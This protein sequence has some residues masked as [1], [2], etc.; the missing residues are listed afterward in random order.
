MRLAVICCLALL[1]IVG[2]AAPITT[3]AELRHWCKEKSQSYFRKKNIT[4]YNGRANGWQQENTL[5]VTGEWR[6]NSK[7]VT[8]DCQL[9]KGS[10]GKRATFKVS[11]Q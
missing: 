11:E 9:N 3:S 5:Y 1:P 4:P 2:Y 7:R 6:V 10:K 8:V